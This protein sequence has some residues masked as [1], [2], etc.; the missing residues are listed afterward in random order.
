MKVYKTSAGNEQLLFQHSVKE[1]LHDN[2]YPWVDRYALAAT[3]Q[4][5]VTMNGDTYVMTPMVAGKDMD[6][7]CADNAKQ[8]MEAVARL[9]MLAR[10]IPLQGEYAIGEILPDYFAKQL[11]ELTSIAKR[12]RKQPRLSDFDVHF[13]KNVNFYTEQIKKA[14]HSL[15]H[16]NY[17]ACYETARA[18]RHVCHNS[19]KEESLVL[20]GA[21]TYVVYW[22]D[23]GLDIQLNDTAAFIRRYVQRAG[24]RALPVTQLLDIYNNVVSL[25]P[26]CATILYAL[27]QFPWNFM[28]IVTAYYSKKRSWTP[29]AMENRMKA[30]VTDR[31]FYAE[32]IRELET[33]ITT[34]I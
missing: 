7:E 20:S 6:F 32:Y 21:Q 3:G 8:A 22:G 27:L 16:T 30:V 12:V 15:T 2:G 18:Q 24:T 9:H 25:T 26:P 28:K 14:I 4:P 29:N 19:L 17:T 10:D 1:H 34:A 5:Y 33:G 31:E 23:A 13:I 11:A